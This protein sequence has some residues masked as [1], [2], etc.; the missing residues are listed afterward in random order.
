M[1]KQLPFIIA[2]VPL[3][4]ISIVLKGQSEITTLQI[5]AYL[6]KDITFNLIRWFA[7]LKLVLGLIM[8]CFS[9]I[10]PLLYFFVFNRALK[11]KI[12]SIFRY[13]L[14]IVTIVSIPEICRQVYIL[15]LAD[16]WWYIINQLFFMYASFVVYNVK[17]NNETP[18]IDIAHYPMVTY[19]SLQH[20]FLHFMLDL[21]LPFSF[22]FY[23]N[24][25]TFTALSLSRKAIMNE[26]F[27][28]SFHFFLFFFL[29]ELLFRKTF[30]KLFTNSCVAGV[31]DLPNASRIFIRTLCR[32]IPLEAISFLFK[33][34]FHDRFSG[35]AVIYNQS[36]KDIVFEN[37]EKTEQQAV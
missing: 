8:T 36:W 6:F 30:A 1:K 17:P 7:I 32:F 9:I 13:F 5:F 19:T 29:S 15:P 14:V 23:W 12:Y 3:V 18:G 25:A 16:S 22:T 20:R 37:E 2:L 10:I 21:L 28:F 33:L 24:P 26:V 4:N 11:Q 35:T 27:Y 31:N 34:N